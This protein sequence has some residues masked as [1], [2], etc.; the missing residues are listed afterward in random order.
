[1]A[2]FER[3]TATR[4][5]IVALENAREND[6]KYRKWLKLELALVL[7]EATGRRLGSIRQLAWE[8]VD[9]TAS[10]IHWR[11][12]NDKK[13][14]EWVVPMPA[15]LREEL[16][17]FRVKLGGTFGGLLF[18][19]ETDSKVPLRRDVLGKWLKQAEA[20]AA[21]PKLDG[22]LWHAYRRSW[23]TSRKDLPTA[24][25]A[26]AGGWSDVGTLLRCYQQPDEATML[27][28]MSHERKV[29]ERTEEG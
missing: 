18:P 15:A 16:R 5:A 7:A 3:F 17:R 19:S 10:S 13:R 8:D 29:V 2:T 27:A 26:A 6:A 9:F 24:D 11:A 25:V 12:A 1:M 20:K 21:L 28:V 4:A 14:K 22:S 23:A